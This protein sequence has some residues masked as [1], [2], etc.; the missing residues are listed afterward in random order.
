MV[1]LPAA[2]APTPAPAGAPSP[3]PAPQDVANILFPADGPQSSAEGTPPAPEGTPPDGAGG[4]TTAGA[5]SAASTESA[6]AYEFTFPEG[7]EADD[8]LI[9]EANEVLAAAGVPKDKAQG[10]MDLYIKG[11]Q[12][13]TA[14][15]ETAFAEQQA[16]WATQISAMPEFQGPTRETSLQAIGKLLD[17]YGP[18]A[19]AGIMNNPL[20]GN[21]PEMA[22][23]LVNVAKALD[24]GTPTPAHRPARPRPATNGELLF[25]GTPEENSIVA[26]RT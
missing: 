16:Q 18:E 4:E 13:Q 6:P 22:K 2:P 15:A 7:F 20:V 11:V 10:L 26:T 25:G 19:K 9:T 17:E 23:F 21:N 8:A 24:E 5:E 3:A 12:A 14:A 1:D